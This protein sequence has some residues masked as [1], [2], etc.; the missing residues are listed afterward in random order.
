[1]RAQKGD[2]IRILSPRRG[3]LGFNKNAEV[4]VF[5]EDGKERQADDNVCLEFTWT[6]LEFDK[7]GNVMRAQNYEDGQ[8][9]PI[10]KP[11]S[12]K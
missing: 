7:D 9:P 2:R 1:M 12:N 11:N 4:A 6:K 3:Y 8:P 5:V 10:N